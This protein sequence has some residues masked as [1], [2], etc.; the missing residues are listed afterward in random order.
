MKLTL[1]E[2]YLFA[3]QMAMILQSGFSM[4]NG[5]VM[6][7]EETEDKELKKVL[8]QVEG[9]LGEGLNL[10]D[11]LMQTDAFDN[12]MIHLTKIGELSG[13]L[14]DVMGSLG[15]YYQRMDDISQKLHQALTYPIVL[16]LMMFVVVGVIVFSVLPIFKN[17][18]EDLGS[19]LSSY[20][21]M[22]MNLG[23][24][25]SFVGFLCLAV[26][27]VM[28]IGVWIYSKIKHV[29]VLT[30]FVQKSIFT[31]KLSKVLNQAQMTYALSLFVSSGYDMNEAMTYIPHFI[32]NQ[33]LKKDIEGCQKDIDEG[34]SFEEAIK[35]NHI[36]QGIY[37]NMIQVAF[38]MGQSEQVM[39]DLS[40]SYQDDVDHAIDRFLN[41]I[42]P[43]IV[44]FLCVVVG[45]VLLSVMMPL[46]SIMSSL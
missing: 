3:H 7:K 36:Y 8:E 34:M 33:K 44:T 20:A 14:D 9:F 45:V 23:Q 24:M 25:F 32:D 16:V 43:T 6:I 40:V 21:Y 18:L 42:E 22:F 13:H 10:S 39:K 28:I 35:K 5:V 27:V 15:D 38:K 30:Q 46:M 31:R 26:L 11:A 17:V 19:H 1:E 29:N 12:Y 41:V 2:K 4:D 37:L